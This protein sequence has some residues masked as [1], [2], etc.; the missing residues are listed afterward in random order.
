MGRKKKQEERRSGPEGHRGRR[1]SGSYWKNAM[2][3][4]WSKYW[5]NFPSN[6][7]RLASC[8]Y[9]HS[10]RNWRLKEERKFHKIMEWVK[11]KTEPIL[12]VVLLV[13]EI[14]KI[15]S[16]LEQRLLASYH[17]VPTW[18]GNVGPTFLG[19]LAAE[20]PLPAAFCPGRGGPAPTGQ[21]HCTLSGGRCT[22]PPGHRGIC[23]FPFVASWGHGWRS[24]HS[25]R[26]CPVFES[27]SDRKDA[28]TWLRK[29]THKSMSTGAKTA[30]WGKMSTKLQ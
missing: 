24:S 13:L 7:M 11:N 10:W 21:C 16:S 25:R 19:S 12:E 9:F 1:N 28:S 20:Q 27:G 30:S 22:P 23:A 17:L 29:K 8:P 5:L 15:C 4:Y 18:A 2:L 26:S 14:I 3:E 6:P